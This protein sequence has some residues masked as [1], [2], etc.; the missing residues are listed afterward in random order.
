MEIERERETFLVDPQ[1][2]SY[3]FLFFFFSFF[4]SHVRR[5]ERRTNRQ[6]NTTQCSETVISMN[7]RKE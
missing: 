3:S 4:C 7:K 5:K 6:A 2:R 1:R